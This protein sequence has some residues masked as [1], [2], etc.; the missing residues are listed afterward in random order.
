[1]GAKR[2]AKEEMG[3]KTTY[4]DGTFKPNCINNFIKCK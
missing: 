3:K 1:M 4:E 2:G